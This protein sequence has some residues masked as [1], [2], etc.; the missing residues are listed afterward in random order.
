MLFLVGFILPKHGAYG[1][2]GEKES[3]PEPV[4]MSQA[5]VSKGSKSK[6]LRRERE[7][8]SIFSRKRGVTWLSEALIG[9][10]MVALL[11]GILGYDFISNSNR[12][13]SVLKTIINSV[14]FY[15]KNDTY[16]LGCLVYC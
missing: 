7:A 16:S 12:L 8:K 2:D 1:I 10:G 6:R 3:Q 9:G 13:S 14:T 5:A 15:R 4:A 11:M